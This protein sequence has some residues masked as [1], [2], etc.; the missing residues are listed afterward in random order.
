M[1][2]QHVQARVRAAMDAQVINEG[3]HQGGRAPYGYVVVDG[4]PHPNPR[5]AAEGFRLRL[6]AIDEPSAEAV[7]RIFSEYLDG[8]G[9]RAIA[10]GLNRDGIPCPSARR[11]DQNRH[12]LADGWQGSTIRAILE[13]PRYTGYA[14]F[15]RWVK[16]ETLVN[17][18]DVAAGHVVRFRRSAPER[19]VRSREQAHPEIVSVEVFTQAQLIRRARGSGGMRGIAKLERT[20]TG[21]KRPYLLRGLMR[22]GVCL[23]RMQAEGIRNGVYYRCIA[24]TLTP[25]SAAL[26]EH[27]KTVNLREDHVV[28]ALNEWL[29]TRFSRDN[30]EDTVAELIGSQ[31]ATVETGSTRAPN[32]VSW[33]RRRA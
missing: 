24:R 9:D 21:G 6:L 14:V 15:G 30:V 10:A 20:R 4:G 16:H 29:G 22:C 31:D 5:K 23:R 19:I 8:A 26:A 25:G 17:P 1:E 33:T 18:D 12:R 2:R 3:R 11:P 13:N 27:P 28:P 32:S 7:R